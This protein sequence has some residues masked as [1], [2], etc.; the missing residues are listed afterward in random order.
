ME[1]IKDPLSQGQTCC[2][3]LSF[4]HLLNRTLNFR[5]PTALA[6][7]P[8]LQQALIES[9]L[10]VFFTIQL[11]LF[12]TGISAPRLPSITMMLF[13]SAQRQQRSLQV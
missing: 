3:L 12:I 4:T 13:T 1:L 7:M 11:R 10:F 6:P 5:P 8:P 9:V 2:L